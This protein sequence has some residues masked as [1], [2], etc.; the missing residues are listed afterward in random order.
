MDRH[1]SKHSSDPPPP[2]AAVRH[3]RARQSLGTGPCLDCGRFLWIAGPRGQF[4]EKIRF[5]DKFFVRDEGVATWLNV[6]LTP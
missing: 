3:R 5:I 4:S 2:Q 1:V 6:V